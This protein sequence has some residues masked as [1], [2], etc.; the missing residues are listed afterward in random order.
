MGASRDRLARFVADGSVRALYS[1]IGVALL[2]RY[3]SRIERLIRAGTLER[4]EGEILVAAAVKRVA[5]RRRV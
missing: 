1:P 4:Y 3:R 5:D 2:L